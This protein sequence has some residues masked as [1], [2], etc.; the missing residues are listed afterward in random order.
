MPKLRTLAGKDLLRLFSSFDFHQHSQKGSHIKLRRTLPSG[1]SQTL[2]I[3]NHAEV[4][5]DTLN[6]IYRQAPRFIPEDQ[7]R[8]HFDID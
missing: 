5:R 2:T 8:P 4:D 1:I 6:A 7:L 3:V